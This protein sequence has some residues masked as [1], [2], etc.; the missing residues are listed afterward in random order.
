MVIDALTLLIGEALQLAHEVVEVL[1]VILS[2]TSGLADLF[3]EILVLHGD[4]SVVG[5]DGQ[6]FQISIGEALFPVEHR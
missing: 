2:Q 5:K 6:E 3:E 1:F 4:R